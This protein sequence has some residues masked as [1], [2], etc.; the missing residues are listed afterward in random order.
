MK[1]SFF[2]GAV[3]IM[4]VAGLL[5]A[6][7]AARSPDGIDGAKFDRSR[8]GGAESANREI[9]VV[10]ELAG[11]PVALHE[12]EAIARGARLTR[13]QR[14]AI[15]AP[16]LD[17][18]RAVQAA[19]RAL[20]GRV[21]GAYQDVF[22]G[23]RVRVTSGKLQAVAR[24]Q[25]V[26]KA[27][28]VQKH[29]M[30]NTNTL[31][32]LGVP[33]TWQSTSTGITGKGVKVAIIDT[34][35]D[36]HHVNFGG[37]GAAAYDGDPGTN[38]RDGSS[39]NDEFPTA[40]VIGG[41]DFAGDAY[42]AS[43]PATDPTCTRVPQ[44]DPDPLDCHGHG[45]HV[46][47]TSAGFGVT[48]AGARYAGPYDSTTLSTRFTI[49]PG[50]APDA[51]ILAYKVFGC[52]GSTDVLVDAIERAYE[53]GAHVI[54]MSVGSPL[55]RP[56]TVEAQASN[57][58]SVAGVTV[59]ASA[60]NS[61]PSAYITGSPASA[62]RSIAVAA[63]DANPS[64]QVSRID[65]PA[66]A[67]DINAQNSN[68]ATI[69]SGGITGGVFVLKDDDHPSGIALGCTPTEYNPLE[70]SGKIVVTR[71]GTCARIARAQFGQ[72]AGAKAVLM[73]NDTPGYPPIEGPIPGV[74][75]PFM[76][77]KGPASKTN[78][79]VV[80]LLASHGKQAT[81]LPS[82]P[83]ANP[84]Y[85]KTAGFSSGGPGR[86]R[87]YLKPDVIAPGVG[88]ISTA[89]G[90]GNEGVRFSGTSM[91]SPAVAGVAALVKQAH[92]T[93]GSVKI[94]SAIVGTA[95]TSTTKIVGYDMRL[96]GA[97]VV[98]PLRAVKTVAFATTPGAIST[99]TFGYDQL[100]GSHRESREIYL[101]NTSGSSITYNL[102]SSFNGPSRGATVAIS[103]STVTVGPRSYQRVIV[104]LSL[105]TTA[106]RAL[107]PARASNSVSD[108]SGIRTTLA[109]IIRGFVTATPTV[110]ATGR[111]QIRVPF[112]SVPRGLSDVEAGTKS[113]Y[114]GTGETVTSTVKLTNYGVRTGN[115]DMYAWGL[116]DGNEGYES[117]DLRAVGVKSIGKSYCDSRVKLPADL[118]DDTFPENDRCLVFAINT[119]GRWSNPSVN[120]FDIVVDTQDC[121]G[122]EVP[123]VCA[124]EDPDLRI[125]GFDYGALTAGSFNGAYGV[126]VFSPD[127]SSMEEFVYLA[128]APANSSTMSLMVH[129]SVLGIQAGSGRDLNYYAESFEIFEGSPGE[130][131]DLATT[132]LLAG[133]KR[134]RFDAFDPA[135]S[136]DHGYLTL[137][138][139]ASATVK[140]T[141]DRGDYEPGSMKG[142]MA[143]T[144]DDRN[145]PYQARVIP[146]GT[147]PEQ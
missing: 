44:P 56:D 95:T 82:Q 107:P 118:P 143:V 85:R 96:A 42:N 33:A 70:V 119:W 133:P 100:K 131:Y 76:G 83:V 15:R 94:K 140:L 98:D 116:T 106:V 55:G 146:V 93:W 59:V 30:D 20:G 26:V 39:D 126:F 88:V 108:A 105:S 17:Q 19:A 46:A 18:Q 121:L 52:D 74:T 28:E 11:R 61:G 115:A 78:P 25:G 21:E 62:A 139:G 68:A 142:W 112:I 110:S 72:A 109:H 27:H 4:L 32:H 9:V 86:V 51:K 92:P 101:H 8:L 122:G 79:D 49:G 50:V 125:V 24:I 5:P 3:S 132:G 77:V 145:G 64:I 45:S 48:S 124:N 127:Y 10:L 147:V 35:V 102:S 54:N 104:T 60:G 136:Q 40:K 1:R 63:L 6:T 120:E 41:Y 99:V 103:P 144:L 13:A 117:S 81:I 129:A 38:P 113:A 58:A 37:T 2:A 138:P 89:V 123:G 23:V 71:R 114:T 69:P 97:G 130:G 47:G 80:A 31:R 36:Y 16:L 66:P 7:V 53:D 34:G 29:Y 75:I 87:D 67:A 141:L 65:L 134:A 12:G 91:S 84:G 128:N 73:V 14:D 137:D 135:L 90:T 111:Y 57:N 43:C 22:N